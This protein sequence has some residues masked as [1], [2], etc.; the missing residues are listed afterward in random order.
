MIFVKMAVLGTLLFVV[1]LVSV[2]PPSVSSHWEACPF[3]SDPS[4]K[5]HHYD[6][7]QDCI[8]ESARCG[9]FCF[10]AECKECTSW[11]HEHD[12][13]HCSQDGCWNH[14]HTHIGHKKPCIRWFWHIFDPDAPKNI[15]DNRSDHFDAPD[16]ITLLEPGGGPDDLD[17]PDS[18]CITEQGDREVLPGREELSLAEPLLGT[19]IP[20][21]PSGVSSIPV[22][23]SGVDPLQSTDYSLAS[24]LSGLRGRPYNAF[25]LT[26]DRPGRIIPLNY[27]NL[28]NSDPAEV[29]ISD[30]SHLPRTPGEPGAPVLSSVTKVTDNSVTLQVSGGSGGVVQYRYWSYHGLRDPSESGSA[31]VEVAP[32]EFRVPFAAL[33][34]TVVIDPALRGIFSFQVR[35]VGADGVSMGNS[36]IRHQMIGM[37]GFH[38]FSPHMIPPPFVRSL[39]EVVPLSTIQ[40]PGFP[41]PTVAP[42]RG[43][44]LPPPDRGM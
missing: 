2:P 17:S 6:Y 8:S 3:P 1:L 16:L 34:G 42:H 25:G 26:A 33:L 4:G 32:T 12:H 19:P 21:I 24:P 39:P 27:G 22:T 29:T 41:L 44:P 11:I 15:G 30:L 35:S 36:N 31:L 9:S 14:I 5:P 7:S 38:T 23:P 43:T 37:A 13:E 40:L 28:E 10:W 20:V 18:V